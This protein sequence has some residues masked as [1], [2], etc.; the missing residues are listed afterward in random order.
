M[1][2]PF[3]RRAALGALPAIATAESIDPVFAA[4]EAHRAAWAAPYGCSETR[5]EVH[6]VPAWPHRDAR[7]RR[8]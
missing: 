5:G 4:I 8:S 7:R 1:K 2:T 3:D 6:G